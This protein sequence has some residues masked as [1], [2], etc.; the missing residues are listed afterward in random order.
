M[1]SLRPTGIRAWP[2]PRLD[3]DT[4][5]VYVWARSSHLVVWNDDL[6]VEKPWW[7]LYTAYDHA[8]TFACVNEIEGERL[9]V[10]LY[11]LIGYFDWFYGT[12]WGFSVQD[13][14]PDNGLEHPTRPKGCE[15]LRVRGICGRREFWLWERGS[16]VGYHKAANASVPFGYDADPFVRR[17]V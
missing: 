5:R 3:E 4:D 2:S 6:R 9:F 13:G 15:L 1:M 7:Y 11:E 17:L 10:P 16:F 14:W 12:V 8:C